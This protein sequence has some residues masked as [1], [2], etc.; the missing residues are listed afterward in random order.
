MRYMTALSV[1]RLISTA[2]GLVGFGE[3]PASPRHG[4]FVE[5]L[6]YAVGRSIDAPWD[7]AFVYYAGHWSQFDHFEE[8]SNWPLP[9]TGFCRE[10]A[11]LEEHGVLNDRPV[12]GDLFLVW[13]RRE[14]AFV[15]CGIVVAVRETGVWGESR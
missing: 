8:R 5:R 9:A 4:P 14:G 12:A 3:D 15:R 13:S 7:A 2:T 6:Q 11:A 1:D 10:L